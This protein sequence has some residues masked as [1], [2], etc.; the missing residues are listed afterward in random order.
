MNYHDFWEDFISPEAP[1]SCDGAECTECVVS[2]L[3]GGGHR[4]RADCA[5]EI[6]TGQK[7]TG[8][9]QGGAPGPPSDSQVEMLKWL[10]LMVHA[11]YM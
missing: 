8:E 6:G 9:L 4:H 11:R 3:A 1:G 10:I 2:R 7:V 5:L